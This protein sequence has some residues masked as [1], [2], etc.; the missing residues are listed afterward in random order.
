M[1]DIKL[2]IANCYNN[3]LERLPVYNPYSGELIANLIKPT[4]DE[5]ELAISNVYEYFDEFRKNYPAYKRAEILYKVSNQI[6][7]NKEELAR[8]IAQEGGKPIKD[9]LIEVNRAVNTVKLSADEALRLNGEQISMDKSPN[10]ISHLAFTIKEPIG[11]VLAIS[12]FNHPI[13]LICHQ[14]A[15]AIAAGNTVI[16]KPSEKT[17]LSAYKI[18]EY[19]FNAGL[20][21]RCISLLPLSGLETEKIISDKR[22]RY[23][24]FIGS[25]KVGW[26]IPKLISNG[27]KYS[28]EH[29]GTATAIIDR[30]VN[31]NYV[32]KSILKG[33]FYHAGQVCVSTQ[34]AYIHKDIFNDFMDLLIAEIK[35]LKTGNP[36][37][38]DTDIGPIIT[39]DKVKI[40][41]NQ[42][43]EAIS[44]G[45]I[46]IY[47]GEYIGNNCITPTILNNTNMTMQIMNEEV[48]GPILNV[49]PYSNI[50][51]LIKQINSSKYSFQDSIYSNDINLSFYF[52]KNVNSKAVIINDST[53]F[54]VDWMPFGGDKDSGFGIGGVKYTIN[55]MTREKLI[56][57][58]QL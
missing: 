15:T 5:I 10:S 11:V 21:N 18:C 43:D 36:I 33:A 23:I 50:D 6:N 12:A 3:S 58:K 52:A 46:K 16:V 17:P 57:I 31:L 49:N 29:G 38:N 9:A 4:N 27:V 24:T 1:D 45:A 8:L 19:F 32:V 44:K 56:I 20:D 25:S 14:V 40:I 28:L 39:N 42:I 37:L 48:F 34:N 53:A 51:E 54:R 41:L 35:D 13:N 47:G 26:K 2:L 55:D 7:E 22:L 30:N